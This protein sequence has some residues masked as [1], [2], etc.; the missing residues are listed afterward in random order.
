MQDWELEF[1]DSES[2]FNEIKS[3]RAK[4]K[5]EMAKN[6]Y[7][8]VTGKSLKVIEFDA[9]N[10][11]LFK[12]GFDQEQINVSDMQKYADNLIKK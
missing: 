10:E 2:M 4:L 7:I 8:S 12:I 9:I 1:S 6:A 3:L 11:M 5:N